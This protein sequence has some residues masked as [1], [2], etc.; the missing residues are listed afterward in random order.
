MSWKVFNLHTKIMCLFLKKILM[1]T[2]RV[3]LIQGFQD[4]DQLLFSARK[5]LPNLLKWQNYQQTSLKNFTGP[6][7]KLD[8][9]NK[10]TKLSST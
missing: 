2:S 7:H 8:E 10:M 3:T 5:S 6:P 4:I 9:K 1:N